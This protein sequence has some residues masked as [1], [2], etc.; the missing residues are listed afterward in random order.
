MTDDKRKQDEIDT[1]LESTITQAFLK[2][3]DAR[4]R[5]IQNQ[6]AGG[7]AYFQGEPYKTAEITSVCLA[8]IS[9]LDYIVENTTDF[10]ERGEY[11][12]DGDTT[13]G[14]PPAGETG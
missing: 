14:T 5:A 4:K 13:S 10:L 3:L 2:G 9:E 1:W 6:L 8:K 11:E 7:A 12:Q